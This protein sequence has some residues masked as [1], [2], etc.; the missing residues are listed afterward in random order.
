VEILLPC[1]SSDLFTISKNYKIVAQSEY[2]YGKWPQQL[3]NSFFTD[4][5]WIVEDLVDMV[6]SRI[7]E[8]IP[9]DTKFDAFDQIGNLILSELN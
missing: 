6:K 4:S 2:S 9:S 8:L 3:G 5:S 1:M 7:K